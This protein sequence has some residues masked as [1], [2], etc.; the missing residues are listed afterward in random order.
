M[1]SARTHDPA[2]ATGRDLRFHPADPS[3]ARTLTVD[4]IDH[5]NAAGFVAPVTVYGPEEAARLRAYVDD[6][7]AAVLGAADR[8]N[9]YSVN[10]YHVVCAGLWDI[11]T[12][13]R[14]VALAQ[15]ILGPGLVCWGSHLFAKL[16]DDGKVVPFHQD[17]IYWPLTP[18]RSVTVWLA[19]DDADAGNA[20][21][22]FV[23][24]SHTVGPIE[25]E[26]LALDGSR[27]LGHQA[28][29]MA[30]RPERYVNT[31]AAGQA[32]LHSD[33]L[34]HG[35][36]ANGSDRR[37][38]GLTLRYAAADVRLIDGYDVW[39]K[40]AVHVGDGDPSGF[41]YDRARPDGEHPDRM[42]DFWGEFDGQ[43]LPTG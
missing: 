32:S 39:R 2:G 36:D 8:R 19:I 26:G 3:A 23:P 12:E 25:H 18:S 42:A 28:T 40:S 7:L 20:A 29:G 5:Y 21:M 41:W 37:R 6:L 27:V 38:A 34:L 30:S 17:G 22:Q 43:P 4:Q 15:D 14:I 33:L 10:S 1:T 35:S 13:P 31:L 11:V 16:P 24:G 9:S